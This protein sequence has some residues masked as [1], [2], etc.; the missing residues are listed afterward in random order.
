[1]AEPHDC[2]ADAAAFVLGALEPGEEDVFRAHLESCARCRAEVAQLEEAAQILP[3]AVP[4]QVPSKDLKRR[5]MAEIAADPRS[6][7]AARPVPRPARSRPLLDWRPVLGRPVLGLG[8]ALVLALAVFVGTRLAGSGSP[9]ASHVIEASVGQ[10]E[11]RVAG[12]RAELIVRRLPQAPPNWIYEVWVEHAHG[13]PA[14][15]DALFGVTT[16]GRAAVD[17]PGGV[18]GVSAVLVTAEPAGGTRVPT[19]K[20][21]IVAT[22]S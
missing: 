22:L 13:A 6:Q 9:G 18:K 7:R 16:A 3:L 1:M 19:T 15:T 12:S 17:V 11:L 10:A 5:L 2:G 20:P 4:Q 21:V 8:A 14:P